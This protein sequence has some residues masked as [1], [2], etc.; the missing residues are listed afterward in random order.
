M[1]ETGT[2]AAG[3]AYSFEVA[4]QSFSFVVATDGYTNDVYGLAEQMKDTVDAAGI[5]G[6]SV[7]ASALHPHLQRLQSRDH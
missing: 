2:P 7:A 4:G 6:L 3:D 1:D 5:E